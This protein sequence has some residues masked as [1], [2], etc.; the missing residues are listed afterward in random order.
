[1]TYERANRPTLLPCF[2]AA[3]CRDE[4]PEARR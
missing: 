4:E 3:G 2:G 1:M